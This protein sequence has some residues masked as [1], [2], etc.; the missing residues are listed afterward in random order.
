MGFS[1]RKRVACTKING[2]LKNKLQCNVRKRKT[3]LYTSHIVHSE[4][5]VHCFFKE[6]SLKYIKFFFP[7]FTCAPAHF[8]V[9]CL[10]NKALII[11][12]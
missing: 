1:Q 8:I 7:V 9:F 4:A 3:K 10:R 5:N 11:L 12:A 2:S 6:K